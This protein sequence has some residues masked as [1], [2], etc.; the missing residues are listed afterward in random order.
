MRRVSN[1]IIYGLVAVNCL[2]GC[3][4]MP[5][6]QK[7]PVLPPDEAPLIVMNKVSSPPVVQVGHMASSPTIEIVDNR[8]GPERYY[9]PGSLE[10][11]RWQDGMSLVPMEAFDPPIEEQLRASLLKK[12]AGTD[13]R[14]ISIELTSFQFVF[15][16][17][18]ELKNESR[19]NVNN[20]LS[21]KEKQQEEREEK[22]RIAD[23][24]AEEHEKQQRELKRSLGMEVEEPTILG[25][26]ASDAATGAFRWMFLDGPRKLS[27]TAFLRRLQKPLPAET[28]H[29]ILN[30]KREGLNCQVIAVVNL[31]YEDGTTHELKADSRLHANVDKSQEIQ[32]QIGTLVAGT[33]ED[34][35]DSIDERD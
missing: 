18:L 30:G 8:P 20:W 22:R 19:A 9:Y 28:P 11:R 25:S 14:S 26:L 2:V 33:I 5:K 7:L 35:T 27:E 24:R 12:Y 23:E 4:L 21:H 34:F 17:R 1:R 6:P 16:Q 3:S 31:T 10:Y 32:L 15:D 13:I 29:F